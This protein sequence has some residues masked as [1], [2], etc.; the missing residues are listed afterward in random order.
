[1][2]FPDF[3]FPDPLVAPASG[4]N[5]L[6]KGLSW[7]TRTLRCHASEAVIYVDQFGNRL[8]CRAVLG[9][10]LLK[11][12]DGQGG[13]RMEWTDLD[14]LI[15]ADELR[16]DGIT[17]TPTR[18]DLVLLTIGTDEQTYEVFPYGG[19]ESCW[20]WADPHQSML[21]VH[22]KL[23]EVEPYSDYA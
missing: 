20:R 10:K 17:L 13:F 2:G 8:P 3:D 16:V 21:R 18:G 7:L 9:N 15:S 6:R 5:L 1:M 14:F 11:L 22:M 4:T 19:T 12:D 23:V